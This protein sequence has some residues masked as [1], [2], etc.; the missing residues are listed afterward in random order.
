MAEHHSPTLSNGNNNCGLM[1]VKQV[2]PS[3][4]PHSLA[5]Q[6][7]YLLGRKRI[8]H[9]S[10]KSIFSLVKVSMLVV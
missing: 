6:C 3:F 10:K 4:G 9:I 1:H 2:A 5:P 8:E 7:I